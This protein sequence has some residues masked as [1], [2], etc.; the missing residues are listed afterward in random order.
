[1]SQVGDL[2]GAQGAAAAGMLGP[3]EHPGLEEGAIDDELPAAL[4]HVEQ[5]NFALWSV[6]FV[7]LLHRHPRHPPAFGGQRVAG[8]RMGLFLHQNLLACSLPSCGDTIGGV[9]M[10]GS[11]PFRSF[12][13]VLV[14]VMAVSEL[15]RRWLVMLQ[16][17]WQLG[18]SH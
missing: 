3:A 11:S 13:G 9:L 5:A 15:R 2:V 4:E 14:V 12:S 17:V 8:A 10:A 1:M 16:S 6:E 7:R 18:M